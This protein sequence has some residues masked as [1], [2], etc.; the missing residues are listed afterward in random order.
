MAKAAELLRCE[1]KSIAAVA[2]ELGFG[3]TALFSRQFRQVT[4]ISP[5]GFRKNT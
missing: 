5:T 1:T 2:R 4:G 3:D